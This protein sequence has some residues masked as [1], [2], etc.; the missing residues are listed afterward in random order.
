MKRKV[1]EDRLEIIRKY[2]SGKE[3]L[4]C[5][6]VGQDL[7]KTHLYTF[8]S[9]HARSLVGIDIKKS[10]LPGV[11]VGNVE[12][13]ELNKKFDV[14]IAGE[15]IEH[16]SNQGE[17]LQRVREHLKENGVLILTT[18]NTFAFR[19]FLDIIIRGFSKPNPEHTCYY[20]YFTLKNLLERHGFKVVEFYYYADTTS[21]WK[22]RY[23]I[24]NLLRF[25]EA[26]SDGMLFAA[27]MTN[28]NKN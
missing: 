25:R 19:R 8:I 7:Q 17:F 15:I 6:S 16:L 22:R 27:R 20:D 18:P 13:M 11:I 9:K 1:L 10:S 3:V 26:F 5:G 23:L 28:K 21:T 24:K 14:I 12:T 4:D 2:V